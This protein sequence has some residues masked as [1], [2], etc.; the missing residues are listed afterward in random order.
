MNRAGKRGG[1]FMSGGEIIGDLAQGALAARA[2]EPDHG[3]SAG[4][5]THESACLNCQTPLI[6]PHCHQCGQAAHV[7]RTLGAFFHDFLHGVFHFEGKIWRTLPALA[8][9]PG[10]MTREYIEPAMSARS[11]CSCSACS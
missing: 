7:H 6:G 10:R 2:L 5:H 11:R 1:Q 3:E 4:G 8:F 9:R